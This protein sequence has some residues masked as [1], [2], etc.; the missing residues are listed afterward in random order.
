MI[1]T[2]DAYLENGSLEATAKSLGIHG[3]TV[4]YRLR[5]T[6]EATGWDPMSS[7]DAYVLLTALKIGYVLDATYSGSSSSH[8]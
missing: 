2:V 6:A 7:R 3:N 8:S 1:E 4:R 5:R